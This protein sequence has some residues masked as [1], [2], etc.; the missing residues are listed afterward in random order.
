MKN[1]CGCSSVSKKPLYYI[2]VYVIYA[3]LR[4]RAHIIIN[5]KK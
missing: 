5:I 4:A 1:N 2:R 3:F